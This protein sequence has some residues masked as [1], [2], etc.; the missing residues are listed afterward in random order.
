[1]QA[2]TRTGHVALGLMKGVP[3]FAAMAVAGAHAEVIVTGGKPQDRVA[4]LCR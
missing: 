2:I 1:M 4:G 3:V